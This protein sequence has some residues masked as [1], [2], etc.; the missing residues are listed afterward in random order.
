MNAVAPRPT[1]DVIPA[2]ASN[3]MAVISR[4]AADPNT[5]VDKLERLLGMYERIT[6]LSAKTAYTAALA[7][8]QPRLPVI[9]ERGGI[10]NNA[11]AVQST[12]AKWED[13]NDAIRPLLAQAGFSLSFRTGLAA[14]G[15]ITVTG[16]LAHTDGHQEET[17]MTLPHDSSGSKNSVQAVGSSTSYGKRYTTIA[18]LNITSRA[19]QDRDDDGVTGGMGAAAQHALTEINIAETP[20]DLRAWKAKN[21][22]GLAKI[23]SAPELREIIALYNRR[24]K[25]AKAGAPANV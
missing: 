16:V 8:L 2:D 18:L 21:F 6:A 5:D 15:K 14:D 1:G 20:D 12:Y 17:T 11:G 10:K 25:A 13:I 23:V 9:D 19:A 22:D 3:L 24:I 7:D 4:A